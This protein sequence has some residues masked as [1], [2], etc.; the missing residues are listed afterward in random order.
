MSVTVKDVGGIIALAA[1]GIGVVWYVKNKAGAVVTAVNPANPN[2]VIN[3]AAKNLVGEQR[4]ANATDRAFAAVDL[5]NPFNESDQ[6]AKDV[7]FGGIKFDPGKWFDFD[8][9]Q[10]ALPEISVDA[11]NP[12]SSENLVYKG[13]N[14]VAGENN[15]A[16]AGDYFFG[17]IDLINPFNKSDDYAKQV[18]NMDEDSRRLKNQKSEGISE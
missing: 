1:L 12:A 5:M 14:K 8:W 10:F 18:Y 9:P 4:L 11:F 15:V 2:N 6:Y 17:L 13:V 7:L 16:T 3:T